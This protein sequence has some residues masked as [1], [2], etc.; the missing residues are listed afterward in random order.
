MQRAIRLLKRQQLEQD[1]ASAWQEWDD[2]GDREVWE[3]VTADGLR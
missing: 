2:S 1:Y 3:G